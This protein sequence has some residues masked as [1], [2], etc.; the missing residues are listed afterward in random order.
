[1]P[2][3]SWCGTVGVVVPVMGIIYAVPRAAMPGQAW[4][5]VKNVGSQLF[6][7]RGRLSDPDPTRVGYSFCITRCRTKPLN[8]RWEHSK[9]VCTHF[10]QMHEW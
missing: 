10:S 4:A 3:V 7:S 5:Q 1:M 9:Q 6:S 2:G 8:P